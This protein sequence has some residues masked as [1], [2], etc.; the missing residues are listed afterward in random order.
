MSSPI[1]TYLAALR[2]ALSSLPAAERD[3]IVREIRTHLDE[4]AARPEAALADLGPAERLAAN[5]LDELA[6]AQAASRRSPLPLLG[7]VL[8]RS[9][10]SLGAL[11]AGTVALL[12]YALAVG[13]LLVAIAE[14]FVPD[15]VGF[16]FVGSEFLAF[17][18]IEPV[19]AG[20]HD[21]LGR[22]LVPVALVAAA[23]FY[24][25]STGLLRWTAR[26]LLQGLPSS[27]LAL[28]L[29]IVL[30]AGCPAGPEVPL[31]DDDDVIVEDLPA[32]LATVFADETEE[33]GATGA[34]VAIYH[35]GTLYLGATGVKTPDGDEAVEPTTLFRIGSTTKMMT[36]TAVLRGVEDGVLSLD[37]TVPDL[38]PGLELDG[39]GD[40]ADV[41]LHHLLSHSSG[42]SDLTPIN[43]GADDDLLQDVTFGL[44][45][46]NAWL[47]APAGSFWNY[48]NPNFSLAAASLERAD[49]RNY[50]RIMR[51]DVFAPLGMDRTLF[52]GEDVAED[53]DFAE[54]LTYDWDGGPGTR[55][56]SAESYDDAWSRPSGFAWSSVIDMALWGRFLIDGHPDVLADASHSALVSRHV[57]TLSFLD[58]LGYGY[59]VLDWTE[60]AAGN[61]WFTLPMRAHD[62]AIPGYAADVRTVPSEDLVVVTLAAGDGAYYGDLY[63]AI[64]TEL[65]GAEPTTRPDPQA[66]TD[67]ADFVGTYE[68]P[69][70][71]GTMIVSVNGNGGLQMELPRLDD[72]GIPYQSSLTP[73]SRGNFAASI[74]NR[75]SVL[76]FVADAATDEPLARWVRHRAFVADR[77][78]ASTPEA[79][80]LP[81][82]ATLR[83][84]LAAPLLR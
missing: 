73:T 10:R 56:A 13:F 35:Q 3:D 69:Y 25:A 23:L 51:D 47:M 24:F 62:G 67:F 65:L 31:D 61:A 83:A 78:L 64:W 5:Y 18:G 49:G 6:F 36:A 9:S 19:P 29:P 37:D 28:A 53:G 8:G 52:L 46:N 1:D 34:A 33:L 48:S 71:V 68:D 39:N 43:T 42:I 57:N 21:V 38:L 75:G 82:A 40:L 41:T 63:E 55:L 4:H 26:S 74:Q 54:S 72:L 77:E 45:S 44:F 14:G 58:Y 2:R 60:A 12:G 22:A 84:R 27:R 16:W 7:A 70:N 32:S 66:D 30:L 81:D 80:E 11:V 76:T 59:G 20:A 15:Q 50:R 17:G 79:R